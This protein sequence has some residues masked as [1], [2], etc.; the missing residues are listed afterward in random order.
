MLCLSPSLQGCNSQFLELVVFSVS[1]TF[2]S[3]TQITLL[4]RNALLTEC[5]QNMRRSGAEQWS[6]L[7]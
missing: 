1:V 2:A 7:L 4:H 6:V 5:D 3:S